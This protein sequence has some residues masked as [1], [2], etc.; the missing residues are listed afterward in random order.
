MSYVHFAW[1]GIVEP[2]PESPAPPLP[3][4][5]GDE[6]QQARGRAHAAHDPDSLREYVAG[7]SLKRVAWKQLAKSGRWYTR[8]GDSGVRQEI[9]LDWQATQL[10]DTEAR[11]ARM[12]PGS[13]VPTTKAAP[14]HSACRTVAWTWLPAP[15]STPTRCC[16]WRSTPKNRKTLGACVECDAADAGCCR[17]GPAAPLVCF[18]PTATDRPARQRRRRPRSARSPLSGA[19]GRLCA[20]SQRHLADRTGPDRRRDGAA[21]CLHPFASRR[22]A[23]CGERC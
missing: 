17:R 13:G 20:G 14:T 5:G 21:A 18:R 22:D 4:R 3:L 2:A 12:A 9:D 10:A 23:S 16:C 6:G 8:T 15:S 1:I 19:G 7:D 11:L